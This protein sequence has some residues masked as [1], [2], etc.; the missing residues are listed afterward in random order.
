MDTWTATIRLSIT[1]PAAQV[2]A[3]PPLP[4][5]ATLDRHDPEHGRATFRV[6]VLAEDLPTAT[7][8]AA[9]TV[10]AAVP[11]TITIVGA[12]VLRQDEAAHLEA[13][14]DPLDLVD[15]TGAAQLLGVKRPRISE[16]ANT[17]SLDFPREVS[18]LSRGRAFT[19]ASIRAFDNRWHRKQGRPPKTA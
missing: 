1:G 14:P 5:G 19:T 13:H 11:G 3:P 4:E 9:A 16:L 2:A 7:A 18:K 6:V 10:T 15:D 12:E 17:Q 8:T